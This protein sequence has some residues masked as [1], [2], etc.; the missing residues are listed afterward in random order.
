M[1]PESGSLAT[2]IPQRESV[3]SVLYSLYVEANCRYCVFK[4]LVPHLEEQS[5]LAC[6]VNA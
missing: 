4:L 5:A 3:I 6:V 2:Y 1:L